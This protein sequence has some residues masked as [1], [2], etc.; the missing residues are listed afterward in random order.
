MPRKT[1][2]S[3]IVEV[4]YQY[5]GSDREFNE[6]LKAVIREYILNTPAPPEEKQAVSKSETA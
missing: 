5:V 6:F 1:K 4:I 3:L 2:E